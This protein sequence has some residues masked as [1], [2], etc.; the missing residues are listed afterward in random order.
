MWKYFTHKNSHKYL[1]V[2]PKLVKSYN[3]TVHSSVMMK[4]KDVNIYNQCIVL[5]R[6]Y[7]DYK[8]ITS[9]SIVKFNMVMM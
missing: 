5:N 4:P 9:N 3:N 8:E 2:L 1:N 7:G 6:L